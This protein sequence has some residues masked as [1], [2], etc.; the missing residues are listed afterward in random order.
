[1]IY[2]HWVDSDLMRLPTVKRLAGRMFTHRSD[3]TEN[4]AHKIGVRV[5]KDGEPY[6]LAFSAD[7]T[8]DKERSASAQTKYF[9]LGNVKLLN[10]PQVSGADLVEAGWSDAGSGT[11]TVYTCTYSA[12]D[13]G[14]SWYKNIIV[15]ITPIKANG[16]I[17]TPEELD[18]YAEMLMES[19]SVTGILGR[20]Q[21]NHNI[22][23]WIQ[24]NITDWSSAWDV[25]DEY[26]D[27]LHRLQA[28]YYELDDDMPTDT[29][30]QQF[31]TD[32]TSVVANVKRADDR[33]VY[34]TGTISGNTAYVILPSAAYLAV[35]NLGVYIRI[36]TAAGEYTL[37][38]IEAIVYPS[39][40]GQL[41][42]GST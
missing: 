16:T 17:L 19:D 36:I 40:I 20:D 8:T 18:D 35:G 39:V 2:E 11:S 30:L 21:K 7:G 41:I 4:N 1:M 29:E 14:L 38:G 15:H 26:D 25:A 28:V 3:V 32:T 24:E 23:L 13:E 6:I 42:T 34:V 33:T 10:R 22:I 12:G 27:L 5:F 37:G 31:I 9:Q